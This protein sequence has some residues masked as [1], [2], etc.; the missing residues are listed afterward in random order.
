MKLSVNE[1]M[2]QKVT[3]KDYMFSGRS[4]VPRRWPRIFVKTELL[5]VWEKQILYIKTPKVV[6]F[7]YIKFSFKSFK[8]VKKKR[9]D[10]FY[11]MLS[12]AHIQ[13]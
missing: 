6:Y 4:V 9:N 5:Y 10:L 2:V 8:I 11:F 1:S 7:S 13:P 12:I 3:Q